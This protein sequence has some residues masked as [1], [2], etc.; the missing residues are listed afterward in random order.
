[1]F[2][3]WSKHEI[4]IQST[5]ELEYVVAFGG[6][7]RKMSKM[8][9]SSLFLAFSGSFRK[10]WTHFVINGLLEPRYHKI[11]RHIHQR[12][13]Y[14]DNGI[15]EGDTYSQSS[16]LRWFQDLFAMSFLPTK[17]NLSC[18]GL[19]TSCLY[20]SGLAFGYWNISKQHYCNIDYAGCVV[21]H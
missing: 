3:K 6:N 9:C 7:R 1:M 2:W 21:V 18:F 17:H 20:R 11:L 15:K 4:V 12:F 10:C 16:H 5:T 8:M 14:L 19:K 13:H